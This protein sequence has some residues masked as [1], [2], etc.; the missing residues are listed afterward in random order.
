MWDLFMDVLLDAFLDSLKM[1]PFLFVAY[2]ILE[3]IEHRSST[4]LERALGSGRFG[5]VGGALLGCVPQCGF[6]V[7]ASNLYAGRVITVGTLVAVFLSTSDEALPLMLAHPES[8]PMMFALLAI[9]VGIAIL[10]GLL[11]DAVAKKLRPKTEGVQES[12]HE[13]CEH[14]HCHCGGHGHGI[15]LS[16]LRHTASIFLFIFVVLILLNLAVEL[17]GEQRLSSLLLSGSVFQPLV[18]GLI[19]FIPNCAAS[20]LLTELYLAG[21]ISF[22][23]AVAGLCTSA[24]VGLAVLFKVN[25]NIREN[26]LIMAVLYVV[27]VVTGMVIQFL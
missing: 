11:V 15:L 24:G 13:L 22:G 2:L 27:G 20:V 12:I 19:G 23:S 1:L 3:Y 26:L 5:A 16:A 6:S 8:Y 7:T 10:A 9:K 25:H 4:K 17:I 18:A 21:S 14:E